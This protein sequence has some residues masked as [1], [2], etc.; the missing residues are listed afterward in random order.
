MIATAAAPDDGLPVSARAGHL[1]HQSSLRETV[2]RHRLLGELGI[3]LLSRG[4]D[5]SYLYSDAD[6]DGY[7]MVV[8][9]GA[10]MR[11]IQLKSSVAGGSTREVPVNVRLAAK[12]SGCVIWTPFDPAMRCF[13]EYRWFGAAPGEPLPDLGT[14]AVR[15]SR[16]SADGVKAIRPGLR[17]LPL[18]RFSRLPDVAALVDHLVGE[19]RA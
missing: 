17:S 6:R 11:H 15:H 4:I 14:R 5:F 8:E 19:V 10:L 9:V 13:T 12:P 7:D 2:F 3:E 18:S 1:T 16:A